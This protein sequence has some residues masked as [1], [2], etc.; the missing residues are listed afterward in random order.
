MSCFSGLTRRH[1][2]YRQNNCIFTN[3][4]INKQ[5]ILKFTEFGFDEGLMDG[6]DAMGYET[7][8]PVQEQVMPAILAGRDILACAQTGTGKTAAFLLP[9][10]QK[11]VTIPHD[12]HKINSLI[13]VPTRELAVQISQTLEGISY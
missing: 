10:I 11:L 12:A 8:T 5:I 9:I 2:T 6:I 1:T 3:Y 13:I 4:L 7:A